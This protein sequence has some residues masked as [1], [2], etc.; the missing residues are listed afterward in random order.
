MLHR[1]LSN[2]V[3]ANLAFALVLLVGTLAYQQLPREKDP[4]INFNWIQVLTQMPGASAEDVEKLITDPLE[5]AVQKVSD[6]KFISS[7]SREGTSSILV[8]F[9]D[10]DEAAFDKRVNDLRREIQNKENAELPE[11]AESP[12]IF[13]ITTANAFPT[14]SLVVSGQADDENLRRQARNVKKDLERI[15]GVDDVLALALHDPEIQVHFRPERLEALGVTAH[16]VAETVQAY[17]RDTSAGTAAIGAEQWLVRVVGTDSDPGYL[18]QLPVITARGEVPLG[19]VAEIVRGREKPAELVR[20]D[21][22]PAVLLSVNKKAGTN[23]LELLDRVNAYLEQRNALADA[24]GVRLV[25]LDDRTEVTREAIRVM[26]NN[27]LLGLALVLVVTWIFL[28]WRMALLISLGIPFSLAGAFWVLD[29][30]GQTLNNSVLLGVVIVLGM[31]VDDAVVV[32]ESIYY[33]LHR[34]LD[35][36]RA[37]LQSLREVFAPVTASVLTTIAAFLPLMLM[38]G[39]VGKFM[40]VIPLVV[41]MA[42]AISMFEAFWM[43]PAHV[44]ALRINFNRPSRVHRARMRATHWLQV[45]YGRAL[46]AV[47]RRPGRSLAVAVLLFAA[48]LGALAAGAVHV[49][50]FAFDPFRLYYVNVQMPVGS[51]LEDTLEVAGR[52]EQKVLHHVQPGEVRAT[53][54]YAGQMFTETEPFFGEHR[55]QVMVSLNPWHEGLRSVD[56]MIEAMRDD[57]LNTAGPARISF[58]RLSDGP[59]TTKPI[60]IKVRGDDFAEV[61][62]AADALQGILRSIPAVSDVSD[63]SSDGRMELVLRLNTDA[64]KRAGLHPAVVTRT[65]RTMMDG[66]IVARMQ[67]QGEKVEV[68][69]RAR[70]DR[71]QDIQSI[72]RQA[73]PLPDG[74]QIAL[75]QLVHYETA[76][77]KGNIR[78]YNL[79]RTI[80]VDAN[81]DKARMDTVAANNRVKEAWAEIAAAHPNISLDFSGELDDIQESLD[82]MLSLFLLGVGLI[83]LI[84]GTQFRSYW[85]PFMI[86]ATVPMAFIG[87]VLGL[88]VTRNPLSLFT[89]YGVVALAGVAVNSAI[90]L[91]SAANERLEQGMSVLHAILYA[92]RRRVIPVLITSLTTI[93][94]L[95]SLAMGWGGHSLVWGPVATAIV[96]GLGFSTLLT[97]F[98]IPLLYRFFMRRSDRREMRS[99]RQPEL[100]N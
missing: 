27:A 70:P 77:G 89:L 18:A 97:L 98:V 31:L 58:L 92:A 64:V 68:R 12:E 37:A 6:I 76:Q 43:L 25:L 44:A 41:T 96:W 45:K 88:M 30:A 50:F 71:R 53:A 1:L 78:H 90:V 29:A 32:V 80:T 13:E 10:M 67:D 34:G 23:T 51:S 84:L 87:V 85:Q 28:G 60:N 42:L 52:I 4:T 91:I 47:M 61:R 75:G 11:E 46:I 65:L 66:E 59:P 3:L 7:N 2:H 74:S 15:A 100:V 56:E 8:R 99:T 63:D 16:D 57:V 82:A 81:I 9:N 26:Q 5:E 21:G 17:F 22:R 40:F 14:A 83:Y 94:G 62:T 48:A 54:V 33:H 19:S 72:L 24:T 20:F 93:A 95:F 39:I 73:V 49:N 86:L 55:G 79:R 69:V 36:M 38:P 35:A